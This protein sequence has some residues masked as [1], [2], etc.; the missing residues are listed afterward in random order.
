MTKYKHGTRGKGGR[1][2]MQKGSLAV[3]GSVP[4]RRGCG[5][6]QSQWNREQQ[7]PVRIQKLEMERWRSEC[8]LTD[9]HTT[10]T[11]APGEVTI[12]PGSSSSS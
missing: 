7:S 6:R 9:T 10:I 2:R 3:Q 12:V 4:G 1:D 11:G 8:P 5:V